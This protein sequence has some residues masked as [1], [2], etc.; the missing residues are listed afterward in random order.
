M[1]I[2][3]EDTSNE[4]GISIWKTSSHSSSDET[5]ISGAGSG[6]NTAGWKSRGLSSPDLKRVRLAY[7]ADTHMLSAYRDVNGDGDLDDAGDLVASATDFTYTTF[8]R[9]TI[10]GRWDSTVRPHV[11]NVVL[12]VVPEPITISLFGLSAILGFIRRRK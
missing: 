1:K 5:M 4:G 11:D 12:D 9:I 2:W 7:D 6:Y 3:Q 10:M 8:T